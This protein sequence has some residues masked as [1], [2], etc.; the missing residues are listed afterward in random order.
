MPT[1]YRIR[2]A[3]AALQDLESI[4]DSIT[5]HEGVPSA[6]R[7][8]DAIFERANALEHQPDRGRIVPEIRE[9]GIVDYRELIEGPY[10]I[11][12]R[13][14]GRDVASVAVLDGR[15]DLDRI[16]VDRAMGR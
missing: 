2:W 13:V 9:V 6:S 7:V 12:Y 10:R 15:R 5:A 11:C 1:R 4:V 3:E 16:L 8:A 14:H